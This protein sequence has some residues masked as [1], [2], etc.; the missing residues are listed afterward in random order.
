VCTFL[1]TRRLSCKRRF[2]PMVLRCPSNASTKLC[3]VRKPLQGLVWL[4]GRIRL[5]LPRKQF[6]KFLTQ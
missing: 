1:D 5:M 2:V 4:S 6:H 3:L